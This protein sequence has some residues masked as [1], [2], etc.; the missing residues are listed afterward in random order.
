MG[1]YLQTRKGRNIEE[2]N[3]RPYVRGGGLLY[4]SR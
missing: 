1:L 3:I 2:Q 4:K